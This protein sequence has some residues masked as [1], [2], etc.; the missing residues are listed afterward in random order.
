MTPPADR[1]ALTVRATTIVDA[2]VSRIGGSGGRYKC[3]YCLCESYPDANQPAHFDQCITHVIR[4]L[5]ADRARLAQEREKAQLEH[6][7]TRGA[8]A[9]WKQSVNRLADAIAPYRHTPEDRELWETAGGDI[10]IEALV[11]RARD[12]RHVGEENQRLEAALVTATQLL[13]VECTCRLIETCERCE[14]IL[15]AQEAAK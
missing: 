6:Q 5:L 11:R 3:R 8:V 12:A 2:A 9:A 10:D 4:D 14:A 7:E 1:D 15:A 13:A